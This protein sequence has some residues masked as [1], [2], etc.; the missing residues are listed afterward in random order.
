V[1]IYLCAFKLVYSTIAYGMLG[2]LHLVYR[3]LAYAC[4]AYN[5]LVVSLDGI[6]T[7]DNGIEI[8]EIVLYFIYNTKFQFKMTR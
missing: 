5:G 6:D 7:T 3:T 1:C 2:S 8:I 4:K